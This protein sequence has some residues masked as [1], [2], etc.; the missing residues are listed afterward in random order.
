[1]DWI[2][3]WVGANQFEKNSWKRLVEFVEQDKRRT[4]MSTKSMIVI[5]ITVTVL[6]AALV[7]NGVAH[8]RTVNSVQA[9]SQIPLVAPPVASGSAN[10][11][12]AEIQVPPATADVALTNGQPNIPGAA[13]LPADE[14]KQDAALEADSMEQTDEDAATEDVA[15]PITIP[16][17]TRL[18]V[19]LG[20][21]L[22]ST[23][24]QPGQTFL[25]TLDQD[26]VVDGQTVVAAGTSVG[27]K[28]VS[29]R[30][31]GP[32]EG[33]ADLQNKT[34]LAKGQRH[35]S[36]SRDFRPQLR[37]SDQRQE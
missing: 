31:A 34:N 14:P 15:Q 20:E 23:I 35:E 29:A 27:G 8:L 21:S 26:V 28:I 24:S 7:F 22:G 17:G 2:V 19:R 33:E 16:A 13:A 4:A 6:S 37:L 12:T 30:S 1:L 9:S 25:A 11:S 32:L 3:G 5:G 10:T 36:C 18:T